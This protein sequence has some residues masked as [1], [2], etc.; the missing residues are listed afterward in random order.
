MV[1]MRPRRVDLREQLER[2][3]AAAP[4]AAARAAAPWA[5]AVLQCGPCG[6]ATSVRAHDRRAEREQR[7]RL[8]TLELAQQWQVERRSPEVEPRSISS[9]GVFQFSQLVLAFVELLPLTHET[10]SGGVTHSFL[11]THALVERCLH[12][13]LPMAKTTPFFA[14]TPSTLLASL[15]CAGTKDFGFFLWVWHGATKVG[16]TADGR[17]RRTQRRRWR[18]PRRGRARHGSRRSWRRIE[19]FETARSAPQ[20]TLGRVTHTFDLSKPPNTH[21]ALWLKATAQPVHTPTPHL[22]L[23]AALP[24]HVC[25]DADLPR[26]LKVLRAAT[27]ALHRR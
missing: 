9:S 27:H 17:R 5:R 11:S 26:T 20:W 25:R 14:A 13:P 6:R 21:G 22:A 10:P 16:S 7:H 3:A 15:H 2:P 8:A 4:A 23:C 12:G 19:H 24:L 1:C 18:R